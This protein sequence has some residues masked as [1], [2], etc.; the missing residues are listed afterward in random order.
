MDFGCGSGVYTIPMA[1]M[2]GENGKVIAVDFQ[3]KW[4]LHWH[5]MSFM[6][7]PVL[8]TFSEK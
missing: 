8:I 7:F 1:K 4:I 5:F 3:K 6:S 2:V